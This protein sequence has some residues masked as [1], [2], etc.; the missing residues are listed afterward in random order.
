MVRGGGRGIIPSLSMLVTL[1]TF[2]FLSQN[3]LQFPLMFNSVEYDASKPSYLQDLLPDL[4][5]FEMPHRGHKLGTMTN[6]F[7]VT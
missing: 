7:Y 6:M 1:K 5:S 3:L 4:F 2:S